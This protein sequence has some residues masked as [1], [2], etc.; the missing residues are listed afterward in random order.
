MLEH[1]KKNGYAI[2]RF[3]IFNL[4]SVEALIQAAEKT[5]SPIVYCLYEFE[6]K[7][8]CQSC[9]EYLIKKLGNEAKVPVAIFSDHV[10][11]LDTCIRIINRGYSGLMIDASRLQYEENVRVT[12]EVV[13]YA[14]KFE[15]FIEGEIGIIQSGR[16]DDVE[17]NVQMELTDPTLANDF[18]ARTNLDCLAVSIGVKSG[19]YDSYPTIDYGLLKEIK[20][21]VNA[22]L[23]L[24]G[25]SGLL[26]KDI[27]KCI[28]NGISFMAWS[29]DI[30]Y[31]FF[32][33]ID[34]IREEK[35]EKCIIPDDIMVPARDKMRDEIINKILQTGSNNRGSEL[36]Y[37]Y[38]EQKYKEKNSGDKT[39][40]YSDNDV[41]TNKIIKVI[42][43]MIVE[44]IK[45]LKIE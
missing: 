3:T 31:A 33:K 38:N 42:S 34:E 10:L 25:A 6:L 2:N 7:N 9:L 41:D 17:K 30:R 40:Y 15:A 8:I 22:I 1:A 20:N 19:F 12:S 4:E 36:I 24:H 32:K 16:R 26:E 45:N 37:L 21:K 39:R 29:T 11:D 5:D 27:K 23:S 13:N 28:E 35:G 44:K 43:E 14:R 18:V